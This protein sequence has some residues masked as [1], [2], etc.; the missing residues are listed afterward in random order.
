MKNAALTSQPHDALSHESPKHEMP[1]PVDRWR[2]AVDEIAV[3]ALA[4][5]DRYPAESIVPEGGE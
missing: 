2:A 3:D 5:A 1:S 4:K